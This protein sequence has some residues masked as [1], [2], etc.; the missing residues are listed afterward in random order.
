[1]KKIVSGVLLVM[2]FGFI[3]ASLSGCEKNDY[4]DPRY[5]STH[6]E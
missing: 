2:I 1:M 4:Q 5:R 6:E 3:L